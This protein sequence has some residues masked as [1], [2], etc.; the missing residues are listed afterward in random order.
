MLKDRHF[1]LTNFREKL[2][3]L[4]LKGKKKTILP[5]CRSTVPIWLTKRWWTLSW[6]SPPRPHLASIES[7]GI[8]DLQSPEV[9]A[10][11]P[12]TSPPHCLS[13]VGT[14]KIC[15]LNRSTSFHLKTYGKLQGPWNRPKPWNRKLTPLR[16]WLRAGFEENPG[17]APPLVDSRLE[18]LAGSCLG[19]SLTSSSTRAS[20]VWR[21][22]FTVVSHFW[23]C[24]KAF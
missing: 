18:F 19:T 7:P 16:G 22:R 12:V 13:Y 2:K 20:L 3:T 10:M 14:Q 17:W 9:T 21:V 5:H 15:F 4:W 6:L 8:W 23:I 24:L 1:F 11:E